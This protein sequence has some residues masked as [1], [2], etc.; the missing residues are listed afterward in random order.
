MHNPLDNYSQMIARIDS[1]C[2][3][4]QEVLGAQITCSD[5]CSSCCTSIS[6]FP[7]EAAAL[8][9]AL[10]SL[11]EEEAMAIRQ[12][13]HDHADGERCPLLQHHRC[14]L[15]HARPVICRTHGLPILYSDGSQRAIDCC[16][17]NTIEG[18]T[19]S[20]NAVIDLDRLN[21]LLVAVNALFVSKTDAVSPPERLTIP[22]A[23]RV[24][25]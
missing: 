15:Y 6:V 1:L 8:N 9:A 3:G 19:L 16:P 14:L 23:L 11:P 17:L 18:E 24:N 7:V 5:G 12:H 20:G 22:E 10:S 4:I 13:V 21:A 2:R 25:P